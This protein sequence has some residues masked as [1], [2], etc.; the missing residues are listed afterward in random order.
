MCQSKW[1][2]MFCDDQFPDKQWS[3]PRMAAAQALGFRAVHG[4]TRR[5]RPQEGQQDPGYF[6][7]SSVWTRCARVWSHCC[8]VQHA[9]HEN[10][11]GKTAAEQ[12]LDL[13]NRVGPRWPGHWGGM[14]EGYLARALESLSG[15]DLKRSYFGG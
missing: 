5:S 15:D 12:H 14:W 1:L 11:V 3:F 13:R 9:R 10:C 6:F 2:L 8:P 7:S 4:E